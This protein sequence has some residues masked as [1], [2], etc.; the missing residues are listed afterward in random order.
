MHTNN[1][2][3]REQFEKKNMKMEKDVKN[4]WWKPIYTWFYQF[5]TNFLVHVFVIVAFAVRCTMNRGIFK[6]VRNT[7][8]VCFR[9]INDFPVSLEFYIVCGAEN[10]FIFWVAMLLSEREI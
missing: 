7:S 9:N 2:E 10:L 5:A 3:K 1:T 8:Y 6:L 4:I